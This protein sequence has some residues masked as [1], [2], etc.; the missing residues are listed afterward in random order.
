MENL[1]YKV[2]FVPFV[3]LLSIFFN[4]ALI[5]NLNWLTWMRFIVWMIIG[6]DCEVATKID[7]S[8]IDSIDWQ[9]F[10][11]IFFTESKTAKH[12]TNRNCRSESPAVKS[13]TGVHSIALK[14]WKKCQC[15][16]SKLSLT[17][18][19]NLLFSI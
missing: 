15:R 9:A 18:I 10:P 16:H 19:T 14:R 5:V 8:L 17:Q 1:K 2:P 3:P 4:V 11:F 13:R 7:L 12:S 6:M